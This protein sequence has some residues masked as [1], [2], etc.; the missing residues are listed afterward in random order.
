[1]AVSNS[2]ALTP[3]RAAACRSA[4]SRISRVIALRIGPG[5]ILFKIAS[6]IDLTARPS[7]SKSGAPRRATTICANALDGFAL[8]DGTVTSASYGLMNTHSGPGCCT[9]SSDT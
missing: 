8:A 6:V 5:D 7:T 3:Y 2:V 4:S 9:I 1:M